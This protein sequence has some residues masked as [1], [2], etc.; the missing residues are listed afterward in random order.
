MCEKQEGKNLGNVLIWKWKLNLKRGT[1]INTPRHSEDFRFQPKIIRSAK[2]GHII[3]IVYPFKFWLHRYFYAKPYNIFATKLHE[4][5][6]RTVLGKN[7]RFILSPLMMPLQ[8]RQYQQEIES[9]N[10]SLAPLRQSIYYS[11]F[12]RTY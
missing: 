8:Y 1:C 3:K 11:Y 5:Y 12:Y 9:E 7:W 2:D 6:W 4:I 10:P